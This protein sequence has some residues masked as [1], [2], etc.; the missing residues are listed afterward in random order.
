[1]TLRTV[2]SF[3]LVAL[4]AHLLAGCQRPAPL[5]PPK[6]EL[7]RRRDEKIDGLLEAVESHDMELRKL[8]GGERVQGHLGSEVR[9]LRTEIG[10]QNLRIK[11]LQAE[12]RKLYKEIASLK[13]ERGALLTRLYQPAIVVLSKLGGRFDL[14]SS[15]AAIR[16]DLTESVAEDKDL[17]SLSRLPNIEQLFLAGPDFTDK[18]LVHLIGLKKVRVLG[19]ENTGTT[20]DG[21]SHLS[22]LTNLVAL[23]LRRT[24]IGNDGLK[25]S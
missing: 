1:M 22:G 17:A 25:H 4:C 18:G 23:R 3:V 21:M 10:K 24:D 2:F 9:T 8:T 16:V 15:G 13:K 5:I 11:R 20:D 7:D 12:D 19:L 6:S 14:N